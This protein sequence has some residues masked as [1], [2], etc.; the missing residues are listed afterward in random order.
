M[1]RPVEA[2]ERLEKKCCDGSDGRLEQGVDRFQCALHFFVVAMMYTKGLQHQIID[3]GG[4]DGELAAS[5]HGLSRWL[6]VLNWVEAR[7]KEGLQKM[8]SEKKYEIDD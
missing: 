4:I 3:A 7:W 5:G 1:V 6:V 2:C 8:Y